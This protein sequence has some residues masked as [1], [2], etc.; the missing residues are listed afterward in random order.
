MK[1]LLKINLFISA[2]LLGIAPYIGPA[3]AQADFM[4]SA[5]F[6]EEQSPLEDAVTHPPL[7]LTPDKSE[8]VRLKS[9]AASVIV[10]NPAHAGALL[11]NSQTLVV[12]PRIPGATHISV[13]GQDGEIIMQRHIIVASPKKNYVRV[14]RSCINQQEEGTCQPTSVYYCPDS[15]HA[16]TVAS[17][18]D[19]SAGGSSGGSAGV[20]ETAED[21]GEE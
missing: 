20:T 16:I 10:G 2:F 9:D 11:D 15:C 19:D 18:D 3:M 21:L 7:R 8:L 14:R 1:F 5:G 12:I 6:R 4:P 17:E 13:L